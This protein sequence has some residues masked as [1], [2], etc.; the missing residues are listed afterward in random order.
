MIGAPGSGK[1]T[2]V[3]NH[4][5]DYV[6]VNRDSLKT[7]EKCLKAAEAAMKEKKYVVIDNTN[8]TAADREPYIKL[9]KDNGYNV[10]AFFINVEKDLAFHN[11][12]QREVNKFRKHSSKRVGRIP[13]H[14]FFKYHELAN[15]KEGFSEVKTVNFAAGPF[16]NADDEKIYFSF[17]KGK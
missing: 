15:T 1:S 10:R 2:F 4:L 9:A 14:S 3:Q 6:R 13:I 16:E 17:V 12:T 5:K 11:D 8:P 7:K